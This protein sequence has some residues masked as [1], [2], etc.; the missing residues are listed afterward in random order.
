MID[1]VA[2]QLE[3]EREQISSRFFD[4]QQIKYPNREV[5]IHTVF[6]N[7]RK[8]FKKQGIYYPVISAKK[9][10]IGRREQGVKLEVQVSLP[11]LLYGTNLWEV[12]PEDLEDVYGALQK[13]IKQTGIEV[14]LDAVRA[15]ILKR[16][17]FSK[18]IRI[19]SV[20]GTAKQV[21]RK[22]SG[23]NYKQ[24]SDFT[25]RDYGDFSDGAAMKFYNDTQGYVIYDKFAEILGNG[26]TNQEEATIKWFH[27]TLQ[28]RDV[29][30]FELSLERKQSMDAVLRRFIPGKRKDFTLSDVMKDSRVSKQILLETFDKVFDKT[31]LPLITLSE[32]QENNLEVFLR[33]KN[34]PMAE[35][36]KLSYWVNMIHKFGLKATLEYMKERMP[37]SSYGRYKKELLETMGKLGSIE[38]EIPSLVGFLRKKHEEFSL[39]SPK[40]D[41]KYC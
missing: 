36:C 33:E 24:S 15:A 21:T 10:K 29:I 17:D 27:D 9:S 28:R 11:K 7:V 40:G 8:A 4:I 31:Y 35:H 37:G 26:Y 1:T 23:F 6:S 41:K 16:V 20:Y 34:L 18:I 32:V 2:L 22:L 25:Y 39:I 12:I 19:P 30:K 14:G 3:C 13:C 38:G 5:A